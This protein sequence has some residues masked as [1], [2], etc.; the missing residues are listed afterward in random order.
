[1]INTTPILLASLVFMLSGYSFADDLTDASDGLCDTIRTC[2][3]EAVAGQDLTGELRQGMA[4]VLTNSCAEMRS[5]VQAVPANHKLYQPAVGCL[6]SMASL[7]CQQLHRAGEVK[8]P[9]CVA[10]EQ[11]AKEASASQ[12]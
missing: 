9:E 5:Q 7:S 10:Y 4:S 3:L 12:Q 2:A 8:T 6:R 11:M 1:M